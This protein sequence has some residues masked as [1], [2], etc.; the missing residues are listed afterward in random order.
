MPAAGGPIP[1]SSKFNVVHATTLNEALGTLP[2]IAESTG[3]EADEGELD[4]T[5]AVEILREAIKGRPPRV[6]DKSRRHVFDRE[7]APQ[8]AY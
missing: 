4:E 1:Q 7:Q 3:R 2:S 6:E 8:K 5:Y